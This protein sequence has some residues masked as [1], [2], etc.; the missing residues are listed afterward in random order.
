LDLVELQLRV[1]AGEP[2]PL[3]QEQVVLTG[4][5]IEARLVAE[6]PAAGW[7]PSTGSVE[8]FEVPG[9][10]RCDAAVVA[11]SEVSAEYDS[12][13]AKVIAHAPDRATA[14]AVLA[15]ALRATEVVGPRTNL[16]MLVSTL[17]EP[18]FVA[19]GVTTRYL[20]EHPDVLTR[21]WPDGD[22]RT[23]ALVAAVMV[24]RVG[25]RS[26]DRRWGFAPAGW[27]NLSVQGQRAR[28]T[29]VDTGDELGVE[30]MTDRTGATQVL[31]GEPPGHDEAGALL[32]DSRAS[33]SVL[34]ELDGDVLSLEIDGRRRT[35]VL[36]CTAAGLTVASPQGTST[37][38]PCPR[39]EDH[40]AAATSAGPIAPLPGTVL[41]VHVEAGARVS[42]GDPLVVIEA[43]KMEHVIRAGHDATVTEV[44][45][46]VGDRVDAGDLLVLLDTD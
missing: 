39:F 42:D 12:L 46:A 15:R 13:V 28:W 6:D 1:A 34:A 4:H 26:A 22:E 35:F 41:S 17:S 33:L 32:P 18:D 30:V 43:M 7:L 38:A 3:T 11:G 25:A 8:W 19:G 44:R 24:D 37:W 20:D 27:R 31:V 16:S 2:L 14:T 29:D 36:T 23:A 45:V 21:R 9:D 40:D 5:A 10:V